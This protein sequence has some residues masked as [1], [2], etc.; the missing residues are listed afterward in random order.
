M[1]RPKGWEP[2]SLFPSWLFA[3]R[4]ARVRASDR[5]LKAVV[6]VGTVDGEQFVPFGTAFVV[7]KDQEGMCFQYL[8]TATHVFRDESRPLCIRVNKTNG[9]MDYP[10][11]RQEWFYFPEAEN[12]RL[13]YDI[14][15]TPIKLDPTIYDIIPVPFEMFCTEEYLAEKQIG[16]GDE[17]IFPGLFMAHRGV[18]RNLPILRTGTVAGLPSEPVRT[19][20]GPIVGFLMEGRSIGGHS[21]SPVF[22]NFL[23]H[24]AFHSDVPQSLPHPSDPRQPY[25]FMGLIRGFLK[26]KDTGEYIAT[27]GNKHDDDLWV[28]SGISIVVP[29]WDI[30]TTLNQDELKTMR[31]DAV[32]KYRDDSEEVPTSSHHRESGSE[33]NPQHLED[34]RRLVDVAARKRPQGD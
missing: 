11:I 27:G 13:Y 2:S 31:K 1:R 22:M 12:F 7:R 3:E 24:R 5:F 25:C 17:L 28:N 14:A 30:A 23:Q 34:F 21:G 15:V 10:P 32:K 9:E 4:E 33:E 16:I 18:G 19:R 26:A 20:D 29:A 8:V 6:Y